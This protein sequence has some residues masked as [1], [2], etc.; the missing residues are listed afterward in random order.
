[1]N[2]RDTVLNLLLSKY[3]SSKLYKTGSSSRLP[4][5]AVA[6]EKPLAEALETPEHK[7]QF[8]RDLALLEKEGLIEV[9][10]VRFEKNNIPTVLHLIDHAGAYAAAGRK[11][12]AETVQETVE[13]LAEAAVKMKEGD[14]KQYVLEAKALTE[15]NR[16]VPK[17]FD[18]DRKHN[19]D[20]LTFL[21]FLSNNTG[22]VM[23]R[24]ASTSLYGDSK[25]FEK[26]LKAK[27]L[28]ILSRIDKENTGEDTEDH[29][30]FAARGIFRWPEM[31]E[32]CGH[33]SFETDE[34]K[35]ITTDGESWG[36][37]ISS[38]T[39][40][41]IRHAR[42]EVINTIL[43]IENKANYLHRINEG[44][45]ADE[46]VVFL[47]GQYSPARARLFELF[48]EGKKPQTA[49]YEWSDIDVGGFQ[50][51]TRLKDQV[52]PDLLP[53][54]MDAET[55]RQY[56]Q[57]TMELPGEKYRKLLENMLKEEKY[58]VFYDVIAYMLENNVRLEQ[59][60]LLL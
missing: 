6:K 11:P 21:V 26:E 50:I 25:Y 53:Y 59:E 44:V 4:Q 54:H 58:A 24:V 1:M 23:E 20:L 40:E 45:K 16:S 14:L 17:V 39:V 33:V 35:K 34:G 41:H 22:T 31:I 19:E 7:E 2:Y 13:M 60:N 9:D 3:E 55:L 36:T 32:F 15:K 29:E 30:L 51:F 28:S 43:F 8:L 46:L 12:K 57:R 42:L 47:A 52:F 56:R 37:I 10:W 27:V 18:Q 38:Q 48:A 5:A 49:V